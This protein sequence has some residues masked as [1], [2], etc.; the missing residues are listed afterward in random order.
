[1]ARASDTVLTG[2]SPVIWGTTYFVTTEFLPPHYPITVAMWRALPAGLLLLLFSRVWPER[3]W[4]GRIFLLGALN[5]TVFL[6]C[7]FIAAYRLPGGVAATVSAT[8]PLMAVFLARLVLGNPLRPTSIIAAVVG[9]GGVALLVL[10][11]KTA[12][13]PIGLAA[14]LGGAA[15]MATGNVLAKKWKSAGMPLVGFT[16]WQLLAGGLLLVPVAFL[17]E[18]RLPPLS[19]ANVAGL[20][21]L[22]VVGGALTYLLWFRGV[23]RLDAAAVSALLFL[24][25]ATAVIIGWALLGQKLNALQLLGVTV[26]LTSVWVSQ[27]SGKSDLPNRRVSLNSPTTSE[28][29]K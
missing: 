3:H 11:P 14:G 2:L 21:W 10:T 17:A 23:L 20:A 7:L 9:I 16:A 6:I 1:M 27:S 13:D 8:Q 18:P 26:V 25:P 15:A 28:A 24:S 4:W 12:L 22:S 29:Q 5:I 19:A